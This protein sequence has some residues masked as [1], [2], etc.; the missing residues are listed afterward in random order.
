MQTP[1]AASGTARSLGLAGERLAATPAPAAGRGGAQV[2]SAHGRGGRRG[3]FVT[4]VRRAVGGGT[5][6]RQRAHGRDERG[7]WAAA[8]P[9][10][11]AAGCHGRCPGP[12]GQ[13][14]QV[15]RARSGTV[16]PRR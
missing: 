11:A 8:A 6:L 7:G 10:R 3:L 15:G 2:T 4:S 5:G 9:S 16:T 13:G 12:G 14:R 1:E